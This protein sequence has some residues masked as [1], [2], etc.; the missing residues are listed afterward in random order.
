L[1]KSDELQLKVGLDARFHMQEG[2]DREQAWVAHIDVRSDGQQA[3][4]DGPIAVGHGPLHNGLLRELGFE[5]APQG[6]AFE[7]GA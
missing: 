4:R 5:F 2:L 6:N 3:L 1:W 7:Q